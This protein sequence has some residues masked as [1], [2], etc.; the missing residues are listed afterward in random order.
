MQQHQRLLANLS[1]LFRGAFATLCILLALGADQ[2][3]AQC[4]GSV[5]TVNDS[6]D[7]GGSSSDVTLRFALTY[8]N[9][10][11]GTA[12]NFSSAI[13][14]STI[15]LARELPLILGTGTVING[16][17]NNITVSGANIYRVFFIGGA[18][19]AGEP[20]STTA[21][22]SNLTIANASAQGGAGSGGGAGLGG[23]I[24]VS[25]TASL[26][27]ANVA[28][29][30]NA[31]TG[32][33]GSGFG[34]GGGMGG[35]GGSGGGG[36]GNNATGGGGRGAFT[37]GASGG[38]SMGGANGGGGSLNSG[39]G[40][41]GEAGSVCFGGAGGFGG[42][43]GTSGGVVGCKPA[44]G[45]GGFGGGAGG[46]AAGNIGGFGGG[47]GFSFLT[48]SLRGGFGGGAG[49]SG[50]VTDTGGGGGAGMGGAIFVMG[51]GSLIVG[52]T[53]TVNGSSVTG[54]PGVGNPSLNA[55]F[56]ALP[57]ASFTVNGAPIPHDAALASAGAELV[58]TS[59]LSLLA[60]FDGEFAAGS[61]TYAGMGSV[62]YTW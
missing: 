17:N 50:N 54:G 57:G 34:G 14:G 28:L 37:G 36:F 8:A 16:G 33:A 10:N 29:A 9:A 7:S 62:R 23:A 1:L 60:R 31:A 12:I 46:G 15:T 55:T 3:H 47:G 61:R 58:V 4:S 21:T 32:G 35:N 20:A 42:G 43:G 51:G 5:C 27:I 49:G 40:V 45:A 41:G 13:A 56:Q 2:A 48:G 6:H 30:K 39:G 11:P 53:L 22:I 44:S 59:R 18:G 52:G 25:S 19:Q 24:F 26:T 38:G